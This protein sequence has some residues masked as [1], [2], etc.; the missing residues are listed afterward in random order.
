M[1]GL[2]LSNLVQKNIDLLC[3]VNDG[4]HMEMTRMPF[5][6]SLFVRNMGREPCVGYH[7]V[8]RQG[9]SVMPGEY[10]LITRKRKK[11]KKE[12]LIK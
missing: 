6:G 2:R 7:H 3:N 4:V 11:K 5:G 12:R 8:I 9:R 1:G 10:H